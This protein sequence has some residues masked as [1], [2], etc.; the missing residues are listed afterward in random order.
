MSETAPESPNLQYLDLEDLLELTRR[1]RAGPVRDVGLLKG[2][3][4]RPR[5]SA[6]GQEAYPNLAAKTA[7]LLHSLVRSHPLVDG[8]NRLGWLA[9][10][11]LL[12]IN[13]VTID[14]SDDDA[15]D[16]VMAAASGELDVPAIAEWFTTH[17]KP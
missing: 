17:S 4:L 7:A 6:F 15:F 10:V 13:G 9:A 2:A 8:N 11:I 14:A 3:A 16:L 1:L 5:A 12:R